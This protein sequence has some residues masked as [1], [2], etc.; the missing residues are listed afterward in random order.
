MSSGNHNSIFKQLSPLNLGTKYFPLIN[1]VIVV[2]IFFE[3]K[4]IYFRDYS[5]IWDGAY[6]L[7][8]GLS[9]Y[10][11]F[12]I[13]LGPVSFYLPALFFYLFGASWL[14]LQLSQLV[15]NISLI[16]I[17]WKLLKK[18][19]PT[20]Y[21]LNLGLVFFT[22]NYVILL[23][24]PWY[25]ITAT[26]LF[27]L[28]ILLILNYKSHTNFLAGVICIACI[29]TKQD[30]GLM[31]IFSSIILVLFTNKDHLDNKVVSIPHNFRNLFKRLTSK[32][33]FFLIFGLF[34][35]SCFFLLIFD[36]SEFS[37]W[38]NYGQFPHNLR[39][40]SLIKTFLS[41]RFILSILC[42]WLA[43]RKKD[44]SLVISFLVL[45]TSSFCSQTSGLQYTAGFFI[46][47][48]PL[49]LYKFYKIS[50]GNY[51]LLSIFPILFLIIN[52]SLDNMGRSY[53]TLKGV[54]KNNFEPYEMRY[55]SR[56]YDAI[57]LNQCAP[58]FKNIYGP[59]SV[60]YQLDLIREDLKRINKNQNLIFLN[61]SELTP[62]Y[63]I[64]NLSPPKNLPLWFHEGVTLFKREK[65][66]IREG[67]INQN[68]D[69]IA[70]QA[71]HEDWSPF[72]DEILNKLILSSN[73]REIGRKQYLSPRGYL[74]DSI[75]DKCESSLSENYSF[76]KKCEMY[77]KPIR[78]FINTNIEKMGSDIPLS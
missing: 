36:N 51:K 66:I 71:A 11:D 73:Y 22:L 67:L 15:I 14:N 18:I 38:F 5:I 59:P 63:S 61:I 28:N 29:F 74:Y 26:F 77:L 20:K 7:T 39:R 65:E 13:P 56:K 16:I 53:S 2:L 35:G 64:L 33:I 43:L 42:L 17:T 46:F 70:L 62:F 76:S 31:S 49:I 69:L 37:Y 45:I 78:F 10:T 41:A 52:S 6:R 54:I 23:S 4:S 27:L 75:S 32:K 55:S 57:H 19:Q 60:C 9:P 8:Q 47:L 40:P 48:A 34:I 25:N 44:I 1:I 30:Y 24:H 50:R 3:R 68:Y 72:Y 21:L 12:G 58:Q